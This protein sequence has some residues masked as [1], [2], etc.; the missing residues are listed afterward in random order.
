VSKLDA[1]TGRAEDYAKYRPAYAPEAISALIDL[2][3]LDSTWVVADVGSG[4]GNLSRH[5]IG[6]AGRTLA[7]EPNDEMRQQAELSLGSS[8]GFSSINATAEET[9]LPDESVD[10]VTAG[11]AL[12]WFDPIPARREFARILKPPKLI[13]VIW[14]RF[15]DGAELPE[16][17]EFLSPS[18]S[19][20]A[21]FVASVREPW[22]GYIG[23]ARSVAYAPLVGDPGYAEFLAAHE[24]SFAARATE[25]KIE[26]QY[27][28]ELIVGPLSR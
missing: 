2:T 25:G 5:L 17:A 6:H 24:R 12:H 7:I 27:T 28:T 3:G 20:H 10:L 13:A 15:D 21:S 19:K 16:T 23:G 1:Y 14:N 26:F 4:T 9:T 22:E 8:P 18:D 11:Q